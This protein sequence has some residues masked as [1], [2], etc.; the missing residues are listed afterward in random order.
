VYWLLVEAEKK[1]MSNR[2]LACTVEGAAEDGHRKP[3]VGH[4]DP[5][6]NFVQGA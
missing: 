1:R 4:V 3:F 5:Y 2:R 6:E